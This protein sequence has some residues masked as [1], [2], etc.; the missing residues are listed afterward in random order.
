MFSLSEYPANVI[1]ADLCYVALARTWRG[2]V[3]QRADTVKRELHSGMHGHGQ[4][5][6]GKCEGRVAPAQMLKRTPAARAP[7]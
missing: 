4:D 3:F 2:V 6:D 5:H 7:M 1:G